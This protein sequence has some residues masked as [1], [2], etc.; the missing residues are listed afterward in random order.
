MSE[1]VKAKRVIGRPFVK[2]QVANPGGRPKTRQVERDMLLAAAPTVVKVYLDA[3][4]ATRNG[5]PNGVPDHDVR[6]KAADRVADR[7]WGKTPIP[8]VGPDGEKLFSGG[9]ALLA[10]L[11][12]VA[13]G[14]QPDEPGDVLDAA[15]LPTLPEAAGEEDGDDT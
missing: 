7:I 1:E 3:M 5:K 4:K 2:G 12:K 13:R 15:E 14:L 11:E 9:E 8:L 10:L 6:V